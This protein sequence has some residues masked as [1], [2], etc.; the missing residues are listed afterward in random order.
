[1]LRSLTSAEGIGI[2]ILALDRGPGIADLSRCLQDGFSTAGT[3]GAGLGAIRRL[4]NLFDVSS[5][6]SIGTAIVA[7]IVSKAESALSSVD[8]GAVCLPMS[9]ESV[10]GDSWVV[11]SSSQR[12][13]ILVIDGL[14]HGLLAATAAQEAVRVFRQASQTDP[15][16]IIQ[17]LHAALRPTRGGAAAV[18]VIDHTTRVLRFTGIGNISGTIVAMGR[19]QGLVS[20]SGTLGHSVRKFQT[21]EYTWPVGASL[22]LH[23]DG[24]STH[25]DLARYP[26]LTI[27]HPA[28]NA[29]VLYRDFRRERDDVT[30]LVARDVDRGTAS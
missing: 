12:T 27:R 8:F 11:K 20:L 21:F 19:R 17:A 2:E 15:A 24:L 25:W 16:E 4:S 9:G 30:V 29:G 23:S 22:V 7:R 28:L 14:G 18:A 5:V 1:M 26:G 3:A 10:C 6:P 13:A